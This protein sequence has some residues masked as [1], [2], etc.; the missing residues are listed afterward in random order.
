MVA[1]E[2]GKGVQPASL[3]YQVVNSACGMSRVRIQLE[4]GR[5]HQ[6]RVQFASRGLP[7]VGERK[8]ST[9]E[10]PCEIALW[11]H[12]IGFYHPKQNTW[13]EFTEEPPSEYPWNTL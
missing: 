6:I 4:T 1:A 3:T 13:M 7:L 2:P 10:D 11:S 5:T 8:Y 12:R 9:L